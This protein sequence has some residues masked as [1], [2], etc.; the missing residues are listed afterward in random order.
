ML[1]KKKSVVFLKFTFRLA[2][3]RLSSK[4]TQEIL[5]LMRTAAMEPGGGD[6]GGVGGFSFTFAR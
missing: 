2:A 4:P 3:Y 6:G 1:Q 5:A